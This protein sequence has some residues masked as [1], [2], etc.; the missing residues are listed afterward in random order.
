[1][2][3]SHPGPVIDAIGNPERI[4][5]RSANSIYSLSKKGE[6]HINALVEIAEKIKL[7]LASYDI[8][9]AV[10]NII[11]KPIEIV[12]LIFNYYVGDDGAEFVSGSEK[13][14]EEV[15]GLVGEEVST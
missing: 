2:F 3:V 7:G 1:M 13:V 9:E 5:A 14:I 15:M 11:K 12:N 4:S 6:D 10:K 8:E